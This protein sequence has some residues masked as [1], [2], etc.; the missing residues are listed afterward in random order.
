MF[1]N[2]IL[3]YLLLA[4]GKMMKEKRDTCPESLSCYLTCDIHTKPEQHPFFLLAAK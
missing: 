1:P 2:E 3:L 4:V